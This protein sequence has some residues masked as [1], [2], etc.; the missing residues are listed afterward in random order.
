MGFFLEVFFLTFFFFGGGEWG[1]GVGGTLS[2]LTLIPSFLLC[3][4]VLSWCD[5]SKGSILH[6]VKHSI[7]DFTRF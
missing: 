1:W 2:V 4:S 6:G 5:G 3:K 7:K